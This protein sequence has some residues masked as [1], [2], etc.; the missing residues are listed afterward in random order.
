MQ[1]AY[2]TG[3]VGALLDEYEKVF[4]ELKQCVQ[5]IPD[6][7]LTII[8]DH[9]TLDDNCKSV[10]T[11]LAHVVNSAFGYAIYV[12]NHHG[13]NLMRPAKVYHTSV[14]DFMSDMDKAFQF[15]VE[16]FEN[17]IDVELEE[18]DQA[19]KMLTNWGQYYDIEQLMEHAIVHVLRHRRQLE[20]F[21]LILAANA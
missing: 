21:K 8:V 12:R 20:K 9:A 6:N 14:I 4:A 11:V 1:K 16:V 13:F 19:K 2:R 7:D 15:N 10:Q 3:A 5:T 18:P 17:I